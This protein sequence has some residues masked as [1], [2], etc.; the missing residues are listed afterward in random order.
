MRKTSSRCITLAGLF[1]I[2]SL[3]VILAGLG[4]SA[5]LKPPVERAVDGTV[6]TKSNT[7]LAGAIVYLKDSKSSSVRTFI[8]DPAGHFHFGQLS[9]SSDYELWSEADGERSKSRNISSFDD[10]NIYTF[11]LKINTGK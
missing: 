11:T 5:Q 9:Q 3:P 10:K 2:V 6:V 7:P 1:C 4:A 8:A